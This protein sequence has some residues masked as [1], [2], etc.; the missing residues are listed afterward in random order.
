MD[1][2]GIFE[3]KETLKS[4]KFKNRAFNY[5]SIIHVFVQNIRNFEFGSGALN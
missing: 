2:L 1:L 5:T 3:A 4:L